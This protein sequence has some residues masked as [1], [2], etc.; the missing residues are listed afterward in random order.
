MSYFLRLEVIQMDDGIF[1]SQKKYASDSLKRFRMECSKPVPTPV[2][3][4]IKLSKDETSKSVDITTYKSLIVS[5]RFL[6][7]TRPDISFGVGVLSSKMI[8]IDAITGVHKK[9]LPEHQGTMLEGQIVEFQLLINEEAKALLSQISK[10]NASPRFESL[11]I[12][13]NLQLEN[14]Q[15]SPEVFE[16]T[17]SQNSGVTQSQILSNSV[18]SFLPVL[19]A[20]SDQSSVV[21]IP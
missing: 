1:V 3:E 21:V 12:S 20:E 2:I 11:E 13:N 19:S 5:L 10:M 15:T 18:A 9:R 17:S 4:K 6:V 16:R 14:S 8:A 7:A